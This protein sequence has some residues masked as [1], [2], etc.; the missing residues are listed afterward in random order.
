MYPLLLQRRRCRWY[1]NHHLYFE[2]KIN[3]NNIGT[4]RPVQPMWSVFVFFVTMIPFFLVLLLVTTTTPMIIG[5]VGL[6]PEVAVV[7]AFSTGSGA[8]PKGI[9]AVSG[10][11]LLPSSTTTG[12]NTSTNITNDA[13]PMRTVTQIPYLE[14][15][16]LF[17][18]NDFPVDP[19]I[20]VSIRAMGLYQFAIVAATTESMNNQSV[21]MGT[22]QFRGV[23]IRVEQGND[24][25]IVFGPI[26][27][28]E[29]KTSQIVS[30]AICAQPPAVAVTHSN[31]DWKSELAGLFTTASTVPAML[32]VDVT[33]VF[34]NNETLS[35][36]T[37]QQ[38]LIGV[39]SDVDDNTTTT[40]QTPTTTVTPVTSPFVTN[41]STPSSPSRNLTTPTAVNPTTTETNITAIPTTMI[42]PP[43]ASPVV[44]PLLPSN[45]VVPAS[46]MVPSYGPSDIPTLRVID[47]PPTTSDMFPGNTP[48]STVI[49]ITIVPT[50]DAACRPNPY[51]RCT[52]HHHHQPTGINI[53]RTIHEILGGWTLFIVTTLLIV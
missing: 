33:V 43:P 8:C 14:S 7:Q 27:N 49:T 46:S 42:S 15:G 19:N 29:S 38:F 12:N 1:I 36:Y 51:L 5:H 2:S 23:L 35:M 24:S 30:D 13:S 48:V 34:S 16:I 21:P 47:T 4:N 11:H 3:N 53:R 40:T 37:Y 26:Q 44:V 52:H 22:N 41:I 45:T 6:F 25:A 10:F 17:T 28:G 50:S 9:P 18:I 32:T 39:I 31:P 20:S